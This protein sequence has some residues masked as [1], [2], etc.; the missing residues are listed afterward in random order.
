MPG[1]ALLLCLCG[2]LVPAPAT[3][4]STAGATSPSV[5]QQRA[6]YQ[7]ALD[8]LNAGRT[9]AFRE[10][11]ESLA[12]YALAPYLDYYEARRRL[13]ALSDAEMLSLQSR[14]G[15]LPAIRILHHRWLKSLGARREW[16]RL[17]NSYRPSADAELRCYHLRALLAGG[18]PDEAMAGVPALWVTDSSQPKACD[19]LFES[20]IAGGH[21]TEGQ[22]WERLQLALAA[23]ERRLGRYLLRFFNGP[24]K[25]WAQ[26]LHD[27]HVDPAQLTRMNVL[28]TD[29]RY[30]RVVIAHGLRRLARQD[31]AAAE[32]AWMQFQDSHGFDAATAQ[33]LTETIVLALARQGTFPGRRAPTATSETFVMAMAEAALAAQN[34]SELQDWIDL[35]PAEQRNDLRWQY[36]LAQALSRTTLNSERATRTYKALAEQRNYYGFL[37]AEQL[38]QGIRLN[39]ATASND[40]RQMAELQRLPAVGR[41]LELYAVGDLLNARREWY[42]LLPTL[43]SVQ[44]YHAAQLTAQIG[45]L[46]QSIL[47]ANAADLWDSVE[48]RFPIAYPAVFQRISYVTAVPQPLLLAVARQESA[49]DPTAVSSANARGLMQLLPP[50]AAQVARRVGVIEPSA[51]DLFDVNRNVELGGHHLAH[52]LQRYGNRRP[53]ALAAYNAGEGRVDRWIRDK[54]DQPMDVWIESV[55]FTETRNYVKNVLAFTQVYGKLLDMPAPMLER[56]EATVN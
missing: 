32:R 10:S 16:S 9:S 38:G 26:A 17:L 42:A 45:W 36:W 30:A 40:P 47:L 28:S 54:G 18:H 6:V 33:A 43:N 11:R 13:S 53:L 23:N 24:L 15:E 44:Q 25:V 35:M 14:H 49:F 3:A 46:P 56:H 4:T 12:D 52:L 41:A 48:L 19:P 8:H 29:D 1:L 21:L 20:W 50:T 37:A 7:Q 5:Y 27:V 51:V 22:V 31:A 2:L 39:G 55:P 34:W